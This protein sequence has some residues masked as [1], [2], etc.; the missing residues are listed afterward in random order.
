MQ[1]G[2]DNG[3][4]F[5]RRRD[6]G[7]PQ[8]NAHAMPSD[9][10]DDRI[11]RKRRGQLG[12][13]R[14]TRGVGRDAHR[15]GVFGPQGQRRRAA[16]IARRLDAARLALHERVANLAV[17]FDGRACG[18]KRL[19]GH[20]ELDSCIDCTREQARCLGKRGARLVFHRVRK[21]VA[22]NR[23]RPIDATLPSGLPLVALHQVRAEVLVG[24]IVREHA[25]LVRAGGD[26]RGRFKISVHGHIDSL[27]VAITCV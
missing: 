8:V 17:A 11:E 16:Q 3:K 2:A 22:R 10:A 21:P 15:H 6:V 24:L 7:L 18:E 14:E 5:G 19:H 4:L 13:A 26:V 20:A 27:L 25:L 23:V 1:H 12:A 9:H